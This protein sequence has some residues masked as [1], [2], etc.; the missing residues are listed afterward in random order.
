[1][2]KIIGT[3][4]KKCKEVV[5]TN[6]SWC[7]DFN[8]SLIVVLIEIQK[9]VFKNKTESK[10]F[11]IDS[12]YFIIALNKSR[13][14]SFLRRPLYHHGIPSCFLRS[15]TFHREFYLMRLNNPRTSARIDKLERSSKMSCFALKIPRDY[16]G[17]DSEG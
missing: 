2:M 17:I 11:L 8:F 7:Y 15:V 3:L 13:I 12:M 14:Q 5:A 1:M 16:K 9:C 10:I 4:R 6:Y